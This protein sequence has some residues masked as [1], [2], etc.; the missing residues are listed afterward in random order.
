MEQLDRANAEILMIFPW[1]TYD[2][3]VD[4]LVELKIR[5]PA[6]RIKI[7]TG[8]NPQSNESHRESIRKL[9]ETGIQVRTIYRPFPHAKTICVDGEV[10]I[11][12]SMNASLSAAQ[13]NF[14]C[15]IMTSTKSECDKFRDLFAKTWLEA[16]FHGAS[17]RDISI[18]VD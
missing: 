17:L 10:L 7:L 5:N 6:L 8:I 14:E 16:L 4:K 15:A 3:L 13:W 11:T 12:G 2:D 9:D 1:I 18:E